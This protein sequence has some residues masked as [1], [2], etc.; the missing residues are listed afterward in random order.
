MTQEVEYL[1]GKYKA[2]SANSITA[3]P[4]NKYTTPQKGKNYTYL[5]GTK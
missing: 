2:L 4:Q 3:P 5:W 1:P